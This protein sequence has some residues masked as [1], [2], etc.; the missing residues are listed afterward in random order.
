MQQSAPAAPS[1]CGTSSLRRNDCFRVNVAPSIDSCRSSRIH[2][3]MLPRCDRIY[4]VEIRGE[5]KMSAI[6]LSRSWAYR[7]YEVNKWLSSIHTL[8]N[9]EPVFRYAP[10]AHYVCLGILLLRRPLAY[11]KASCKH[12]GPSQHGFLDQGD[13]KCRS[14]W[15]ARFQSVTPAP[16]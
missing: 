6:L 11:L 7:A 8:Q 14:Q 9:I 1:H 16:P 2:T 10:V 12:N 13:V 5:L 15:L 4:R 3:I